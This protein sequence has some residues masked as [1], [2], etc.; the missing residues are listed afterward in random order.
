MS[1]KKQPPVP[2]KD[3]QKAKSK[4]TASAPK[5]WPWIPL[6]ILLLLTLIVFWPATRNGFTNWDDPL[7]V[8]ENPMMRKLDKQVMHEIFTQPVAFHYHPLTMLSLVMDYNLAFD[9]KTGQADP[10]PFHRTNVLL[11]VLNTLLLFWF[12]YRLLNK[13]W[14]PAFFVAAV[15]GIHPMHVESV[16][17]ITERKD[18]LFGLFYLLSLLGYQQYRKD[19]KYGWLA[20]SV[21]A[22]LLSLMAKVSA[23]TLPVVLLL[24]DVYE[25]RKWALA[26]WAEKLPYFILALVF[27]LIIIRTQSQ[28]AI[29]EFGF[30]SPY[31]RLLVGS[32]SLGFYLI[33][34]I[35][36][37]N[38]SSYYPYPDFILDKSLSAAWWFHAMPLLWIGIGAALYFAY[39]KNKGMFFALGMFLVP[40]LLFLQFYSS[41]PNITTDRYTYLPYIGLALAAYFGYEYIVSRKSSYKIPLAIVAGVFLLVLAI[42]AH[43]RIKVWQNSE[44]L[45]SDVIR[46]FPKVE[47][48]Y[49]NRGNYYAREKNDLDRAMKDYQVLIDMKT[50]DAGAW[51][52]IGNVYG[53]KNDFENARLAYDKAITYDSAN[54]EA[55]LNRGITYAKQKQYAQALRDMDHA[56]ALQPANIQYRATRAYASLESANFDQALDDYNQLIARQPDNALHYMNRGIVYFNKKNLTQA[57]SDFETVVGLQPANAEALY[58]LSLVYNGLGDRRKALDMAMKAKS[59]GFAVSGS[60]LAG[61]K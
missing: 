39:R 3:K 57:R 40:L 42:G 56:V 50:K 30:I 13:S 44:T 6:S 36:P 12:L 37:V 48:A 29:T 55:Y 43:E 34:F 15:F 47:V 60:Y 22:F 31:H 28:G 52:N 23:V 35:F 58:N 19:L 18:V 61:L 5:K 33:K 54:A 11:H 38:L 32:Y 27:G 7:Y 59:A 8:T 51:S 9:P 45:W 49:K 46:Q 16:A 25:R 53:L 26:L 2:S 17:W 14:V 4:T 41:G 21:I 24:M 1:T 20:A 10:A